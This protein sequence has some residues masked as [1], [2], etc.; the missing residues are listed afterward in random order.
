LS[1]LPPSPENVNIVVS[2]VLERDPHKSLPS[3]VGRVSFFPFEGAS[4]L[5][6]GIECAKGNVTSVTVSSRI[7]QTKKMAPPTLG[8]FISNGIVSK[9]NSGIP[10][11][12]FTHNTPPLSLSIPPLH[13]HC[14]NTRRNTQSTQMDRVRGRRG[15]RE[16]GRM[17]RW[18]R[19]RR[20]RRRARKRESERPFC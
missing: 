3:D 1:V 18:R 13:S 14:S 11:L 19:R 17:E 12:N 5:F 2:D 8:E 4:L 7:P 20:E 9:M 15:E 6:E 10:P 16:R